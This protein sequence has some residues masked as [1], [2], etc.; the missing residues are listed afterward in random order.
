MCDDKCSAALLIWLPEGPKQLSV[1][2]RLCNIL[3]QCLGPG[4]C[5]YYKKGCFILMRQLLSKVLIKP[6]ARPAVASLVS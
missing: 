6:G 2:M 3:Y 1:L 5:D 4:I